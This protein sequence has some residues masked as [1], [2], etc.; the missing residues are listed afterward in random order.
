[1]M[2]KEGAFDKNVYVNES[3]DPYKPCIARD[4]LGKT[5]SIDTSDV[6]EVFISGASQSGKTTIAK[7]I[8]D[9]VLRFQGTNAI[10]GKEA[11]AVVATSKPQDFI[12]YN[13]I[14]T[15]DNYQMLLHALQR[16][17]EELKRRKNELVSAGVTH[18]KMLGELPYVLVIDEAHHVLKRNKSNPIQIEI[19]DLCEK[20]IREGAAHSILLIVISQKA[21]KSELDIS[22][23]E[24]IVISGR[25][26]S[27]TISEELFGT[28]LAAK[29]ILQGG[30]L[31][32]KDKCGI[33]IIKGASRN[34][35][36]IHL[37]KN[38]NT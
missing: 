2:L 7:R 38:G 19:C 14:D 33:Q 10:N 3:L 9:H 12:E 8:I 37:D 35:N 29:S 36:L 20:I 34:P 32:M 15:S 17:V 6:G 4:G 26:D 28:A 16:A 27:T 13:P 30:I 22:L 1:M 21:Q 24:G 11:R 18:S 25:Q 23:R 31:M 5:I